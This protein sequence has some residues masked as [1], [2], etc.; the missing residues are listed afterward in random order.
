MAIPTL[1]YGHPA[2][3]PATISNVGIFLNVVPDISWSFLNIN[4]PP[5]PDDELLYPTYPTTILIYSP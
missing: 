2:P 4:V 1:A 5:P 3:P